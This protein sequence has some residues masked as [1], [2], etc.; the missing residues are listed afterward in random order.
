MK[1]QVTR[2][3]RYDYLG[4][5]YASMYP[6]L[7]RY[8]ATMLPQ[9]GID[10]LRE[11]RISKGRLL[12]PY[13]GSGSSFASG[14]EC[15]LTEMEGYDI[16][17][18][19]ALISKV[20]FTKLSIQEII[21]TRKV[22]RNDLYEFLKDEDNIKKLKRP[23]VTNIEFW[24]S[25]EVIANL[26]AVKYF[27]EEIKNEHIRDF[28]FIPFSET[29]R[30]CSYTRNSEFKLYRMKSEDILNFNP[31]V[32][33]VFFKKL[34]DTIYLY[35]NFYFPGL[36]KAKVKIYASSFRPQNKLFDVVLTSPPYGDSR[37]TVAYGQ[38]S[39]FSNEW[40]GIKNARKI[41]QMLMGGGKSGYIIS[42]GLIA[43]YVAQI[44]GIDYKRALDVSAF[45]NDL[46]NS[47]QKVAESVSKRGKVIYVVGNRTV[48]KVLLPTDQFIAEKF[49]ENGFKHL[50]TYERAISNKAMPSK[51]SPTNESGK[52]MNTML[53]EYIVVCEKVT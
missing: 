46:K 8:P 15:G 25:Q 28:F 40:L 36:S 12:D 23:L 16:N 51:N 3:Y 31:D 43:D 38:F 34:E 11:F 47:I 21:E 9:I 19:A 2:N 52:T 42:E 13:C 5:S 14:L 6:N 33:G 24:F 4:Q 29:V 49:E 1:Y 37:T 20:K 45:Y 50:I 27:I 35:T 10:I 48:K 41:D 30:E 32:I 26:C 18:L 22:F 7:H 17:P 39:T 53:Y 44:A